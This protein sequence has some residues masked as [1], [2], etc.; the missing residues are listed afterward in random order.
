MELTLSRA[1]KE[2]TNAHHQKHG[3]KENLLEETIKQ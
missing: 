3:M 1:E 2:E